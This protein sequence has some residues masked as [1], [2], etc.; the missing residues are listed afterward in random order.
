MEVIAFI[1]YAAIATAFVNIV[2]APRKNND[3][4]EN[5]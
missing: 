4:S 1:G 5:E 2:T 3:N